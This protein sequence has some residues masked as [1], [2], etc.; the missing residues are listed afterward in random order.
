MTSPSESSPPGPAA[1]N[2]R[3][4]AAVEL[5]E[6]VRTDLGAARLPLALPGADAARL[7][8]RNALA[9]LDDYILPRFR[10]LDA[11][12]LAVV[13]GSTGAGKSTLVNA[14]VGHPVTRAGAIRPT[15]RQ[16][17]LLHHPADAA[18]F[19]DQ[20]V[21]PSLSRIRGT[22]V[23]TQ[24]P[25]NRAGAAPDAA[26][27][28]SLVLVGHPA[29]PEGIALLDAPDVDSVSDDNR[30]LAG[31]LLAAADLWLFVTTANRYAD[32]VPWKLL[33]DAASRDIM[34]A[35]VLDRVPPAAE[36]EV[37]TDLR[38]M[39]QRE[40]LGAARLFII[41]EVTLDGLGML[42]DGAVEPLAR[43]VRELA[44]D[45]AGR[46]DIARRTL[47]GTV[48]A[49]S[50]RVAALAQAS[51]EQQQS[52]DVLA[53]DAR[54]AYQDAVARIL[55]A[56]RDGALL[57]GEV[58]AR[59]QDF[60]GTGEFFR[61]LEQNIGRMRDRMGAFFRGEPAPA[62]KVE[63]AIET[64]LQAV[65]I[66][67]A[68]TAAED[69][70]QRWRSDPAGRQLLGTD[71]L[72]GTGPGFPDKV[73]AEIRAWQ[74]A[75]MELIR[76]EGQG[77]RTQARWLSFGVNGLGAALMIVVFSMTAGLTGL[78]IGVAGG[79]AVVGQRLL[80]AVFGEDAVRRLAKTAREDL[81]ARCHKL[82]QAEQQRFLDRL[83]VST[84]VSP[85]VLSGHARALQRLAESA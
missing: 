18:W 39:L 21:L 13:G 69:A 33:L 34:V 15:T 61:V 50:G 58:L 65:I 31:Q 75:L 27:I 25:A 68:A 49:L 10:S 7:D 84:G 37:S 41:P 48:R 66:D 20:R 40:G 35:V 29:V 59:W 8:I 80:E 57:R 56:T 76:T 83:D 23:D 53:K 51:L 60:V 62:V 71:D 16:P 9:Q 81:N 55:D 46:A 64:G 44:A 73:A 70:D 77:K 26:S 30:K 52:R 82:L 24:L 36:A 47:N 38:M 45:A 3:A 78:E 85:D 6:A 72:S 12:L 19:E 43:W 63:T 1:Q 74:E 5:L 32:A 2:T 14:L 17:I 67:E 54:A 11:P 4:A 42:P 28:S 22:V 79:T